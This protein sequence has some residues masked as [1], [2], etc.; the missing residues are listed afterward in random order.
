MIAPRVFRS[1]AFKVAIRFVRVATFFEYPLRYP[2]E[3]NAS[4]GSCF[5]CIPSYVE[6]QA[7]NGWNVSILR[8][9]K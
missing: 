8:A 5:Y 2:A 7:G 9:T 6:I 1:S 3:Q 4:T